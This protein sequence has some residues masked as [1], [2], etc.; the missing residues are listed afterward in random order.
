MGL[1]KAPSTNIGTPNETQPTVWQK[2]PLLP[3]GQDH[4]CTDG[5]DELSISLC[6]SSLCLKYSSQE[7]TLLEHKLRLPLIYVQSGSVSKESWS[8]VELRSAPLLSPADLCTRHYTTPA[9][10]PIPVPDDSRPSFPNTHHQRRHRQYTCH[11]QA[12]CRTWRLPVIA[13]TLASQCC[14][15]EQ[16]SVTCINQ[17]LMGVPPRHTVGLAPLSPILP[18]LLRTGAF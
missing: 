7:L 14:F 12:G 15:Y 18:S 17:P 1:L 10:V 3:P 5:T 11:N 16:P 8:I 13:T 9:C 2:R 6:V 4:P